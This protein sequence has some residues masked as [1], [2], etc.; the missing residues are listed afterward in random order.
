ML[1]LYHLC[2]L[3]NNYKVNKH[4]IQYSTA[5]DSP[6]PGILILEEQKARHGMDIATVSIS[7]QWITSG[8]I[9]FVQGYYCLLAA[10]TT[11]TRARTHVHEHA[12]TLSVC[13]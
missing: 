12:H 2:C 5:V 13:F 10:L 3:Q 11:N 1:A 9:L 8:V 7:L 4:F 6:P